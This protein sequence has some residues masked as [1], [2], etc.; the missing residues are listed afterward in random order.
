MRK[1]ILHYHI[2]KNSGTSFDR[3]LAHNFGDRHELFDGP[4]PFFGIDQDQVDRIVMRRPDAVAFSSHQISLPQPSSVEYHVLAAAFVRNPFLRIA[5]IHRFK[6]GE[7]PSGNPLR[8]MASKIVSRQGETFERGKDE[9][10][11]PASITT[12]AMAAHRMEFAEWIEHCLND[13]GEIGNVSNAQT[14]FFAAAYR[15]RPQ[16]KREPSGLLYD[17]PAALRTLTTVELL[18]RTEHFEADVRRMGDILAGHGIPF[19]LPSRT[20]HNVTLS[21]DATVDEQVAEL[22]GGLPAE[23]RLRLMEANRQD[24]ALYERACEL[25]EQDHRV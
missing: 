22:L 8:R 6:R 25:I 1:V 9:G 23:L 4:Y 2:Y 12:T 17:L 15:M 11:V 3:V 7:F 14:R 24:L 18:G 13:K 5:S 20:R 19:E 16:Q 21:S 10:T